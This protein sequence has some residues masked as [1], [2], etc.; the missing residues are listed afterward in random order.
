MT[1]SNTQKAKLLILFE[2]LRHDTDAEH[3]LKTKEI[4]DRL[5]Q[6]GIS[7]DRRTL[8]KDIMTLNEQGFEVM[9]SMGFCGVSKDK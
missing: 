7:C 9:S 1:K 2:M 6:R 3:P 5:A 4:C 8:S